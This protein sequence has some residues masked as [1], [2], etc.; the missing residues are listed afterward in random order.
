[1]K[2][3]YAI[4]VEQRFIFQRFEG[5][6]TLARLVDC[7]QRLW[8]DPD[9]HASYNG[10]VDVSRVSPRASF[11]DLQAFFEFVRARPE[12]SRGRWA[13]VTSSP[14]MTACAMLY[15]KALASHHAFAVF[16]SPEAAYSFLHFNPPASAPEMRVWQVP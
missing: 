8:A 5:E 2:F 12:H 6:M 13:A 15:Q 4:D 3:S 11:D 10:F 7:L 14:F 1:M 16:S 9:Y